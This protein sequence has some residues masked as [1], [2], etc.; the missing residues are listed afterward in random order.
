MICVGGSVAKRSAGQDRSGATERPFHTVTLFNRRRAP[1]F[2]L[3]LQAGSVSDP[4]AQAQDAYSDVLVGLGDLRNLARE[5]AK[6]TVDPSKTRIAADGSPGSIKLTYLV[7]SAGEPRGDGPVRRLSKDD[8]VVLLRSV[9]EAD[10]SLLQVLADNGTVDM[11]P[12]H[13][14]APRTGWLTVDSCFRASDAAGRVAYLHPTSP[15]LRLAAELVSLRLLL[16]LQETVRLPLAHR[17]RLESHAISS[18]TL[19]A[20]HRTAGPRPPVAL[21]AWLR[22][23]GHAAL[24]A[25]LAAE[26][27]R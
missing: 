13:T 12:A 7:R 19:R 18:A 15:T 22:G 10:P 1:L 5:T 4:S 27:R 8:A 14:W 24:A 25:T 17:W 6:L 26:F 20:L 2:Q 3:T 21:I 11:C 16:G 23:H 9:A